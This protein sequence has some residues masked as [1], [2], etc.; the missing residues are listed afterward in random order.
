M[1]AFTTHAVEM[2]SAVLQETGGQFKAGQ[3]QD[4]KSSARGQGERIALFI[5]FSV[6]NTKH[7]P[8]ALNENYP[9]KLPKQSHLSVT[10]IRY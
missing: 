3:F 9:S 5:T 1:N 10:N 2:S 8:Y 7:E 4:V 6:T